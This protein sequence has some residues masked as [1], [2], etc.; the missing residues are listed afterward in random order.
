M[1]A[2]MHLKRG[3][4]SIG[5]G[6]DPWPQTCSLLPPVFQRQEQCFTIS[7]IEGAPNPPVQHTQKK[8]NILCSTFYLPTARCCFIGK[9]CRAGMR[10]RHMLQNNTKFKKKK[11]GKKRTTTT[12]T[13]R[14]CPPPTACYCYW[15]NTYTQQT[16]SLVQKKYDPEWLGYYHFACDF[17]RSPSTSKHFYIQ[18]SPERVVF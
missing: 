12:L 11:E 1:P 17:D 6:E 14:T 10:G 9:G 5:F 4:I 2:L 8:K 3:M 15:C 16:T 18:K 7:Q 13:E